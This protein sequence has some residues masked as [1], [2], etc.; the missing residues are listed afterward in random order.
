[1][2]EV[3]MS[4]VNFVDRFGREPHAVHVVHGDAAAIEEQAAVSN[5]HDVA[6]ATA[7]GQGA[8][9][10]AAQDNDGGTRGIRHGGVTA[11]VTDWL[12]CEDG[13][14]VSTFRLFG[15]GAAT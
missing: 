12:R 15:G 3:E 1:M 10:A 4:D 5:L 13:G 9:G 6:G 14:W 2:I 8:N 11:Q 7:I